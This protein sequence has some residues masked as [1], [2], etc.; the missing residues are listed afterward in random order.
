MKAIHAVWKNGQIVPTQPVDWPDGTTLSVEPIDEP[1]TG[2]SEEDLL[3]GDPKSIA[4]WVAFYEAL[5]PMRMSASEEAEWQAAR[6][7]MKDYTIAKMLERSI[8][9]VP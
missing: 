7:Q 5:P 6:Q 3:G 8:E 2:G 4:R 9:D 1:G